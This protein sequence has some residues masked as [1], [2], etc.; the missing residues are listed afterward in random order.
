MTLYLIAPEEYNQACGYIKGMHD[1]AM[2]LK[3]KGYNERR[4]KPRPKQIKG[5]NLEVPDIVA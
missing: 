4:E 5:H 3:E 2:I 1:A